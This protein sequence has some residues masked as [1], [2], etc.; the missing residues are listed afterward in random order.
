[1]TQSAWIICDFSWN[2]ILIYL[3]TM[4]RNLTLKNLLYCLIYDVFNL[5]Y[6]RYLTDL[7]YCYVSS[8]WNLS[9]DIVNYHLFSLQKFSSNYIVSSFVEIL[10]SLMHTHNWFNDLP[11]MLMKAWRR[12]VL[13]AMR[14]PVPPAL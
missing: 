8:P 4:S 11:T 5:A 3:F 9:I 7:Q 14:L 2:G 6:H 12:C 10:S 1:M 13:S